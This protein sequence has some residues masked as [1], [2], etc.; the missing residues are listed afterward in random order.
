M[1][2]NNGANGPQ[3]SAAWAD[4]EPRSISPNS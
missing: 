2:Q 1:M 3:T 4:H